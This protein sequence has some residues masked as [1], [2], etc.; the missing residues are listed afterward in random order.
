MT[1]WFAIFAGVALKSTVVLGAAWLTAFLLRGRSAAGRHLVWTASS[2][3]VLALPFL[4]A[5][6]PV[7]PVAV[8]GAM[9]LDVSVVF[10]TTATA[11]AN[12]SLPQRSLA[13]APAQPAPWRP[14]W[15]LSLMLLWAAGAAT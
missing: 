4:T 14:D 9:P 2:A 13:A 10:R 15:R 7:L 1:D 12:V 11:R 8:A 5:A 6:L 3:A